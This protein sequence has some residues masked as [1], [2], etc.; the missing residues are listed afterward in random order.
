MEH[1]FRCQEFP[2]SDESVS[3][4]ESAPAHMAAR[5]AM[6]LE[7]PAFVAQRSSKVERKEAA[8][9]FFPEQLQ[10]KVPW[11]LLRISMSCAQ[12]Q[13]LRWREVLEHQVSSKADDVIVII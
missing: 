3:S 5:K 4:S 6:H 7:P 1:D 9:R 11:R 13:L 8:K 10:L 12:Q 2:T